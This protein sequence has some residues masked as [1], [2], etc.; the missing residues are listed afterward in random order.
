MWTSGCW[1]WQTTRYDWAA[2]GTGSLKQPDWVWSPAHYTWT[3]RGYVYVQG[4]WDYDISHRG[5]MFAPVYYDQPVY[6]R[7]DYYY[8]PTI[9]ID[10]G[11]I[12][13]HLFVR[14]TSHQYY[15][16]DYYDHRY[17]ERGFFPW[18]SK[19]VMRYGNDPLYAHYRSAQLRQDPELGR[20]CG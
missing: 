3:P 15:F 16:G 17:E 20:P 19:Q 14:P 4:Y 9:V 18:Y 13:A 12:T 10:L 2:G 5:V 11:A 1:V 8:S 6:R 7:P